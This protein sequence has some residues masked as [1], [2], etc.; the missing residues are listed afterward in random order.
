MRASVRPHSLLARGCKWLFVAARLSFPVATPTE[1]DGQLLG[2]VLMCGL[3]SRSRGVAL[4]LMMTS[5]DDDDD[6]D[7]GDT[8]A[9]IFCSF[10]HIASCLTQRRQMLE[11]REKSAPTTK[12]AIS[13]LALDQNPPGSRARS[14]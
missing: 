1:E 6:D 10:S 9:T 7:D 5:A 13:S 2:H 11:R 8:R 12:R 3:H 4:T 14:L